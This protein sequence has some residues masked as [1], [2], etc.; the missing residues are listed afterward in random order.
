V[1]FW[2]RRVREYGEHS[3]LNVAHSAQEL[4]AVTEF[5]KREII[6]F[7]RSSLQ[8][9]ERVVLDFGCGPGRFTSDLAS[10]LRGRAVGID[11]VASLVE[12][13]RS[14]GYADVEF[15]LMREGHVPLDDCSVDVVW[16]CLVLGGLKGRMLRRSIAE[17]DRTLRP[18]GLLFMVENT[19][20]KPD[21]RHWVFRS[22][23]EYV[24]LFSFARL[25]HLHDYTDLGERISIFAGRKL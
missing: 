20:D 3:V 12:I 13:A 4:D 14:K 11:P 9:Y 16:I 21:A 1:K 25:A 7:F 15:Q 2:E 6:P 17:I 5:Q 18:G 8:G 24:E 10:L 22:V 23:D 19:S